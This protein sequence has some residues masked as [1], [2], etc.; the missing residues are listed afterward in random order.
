MCEGAVRVDAAL[1][2]QLQQAAG[3]LLGVRDVTELG[4]DGRQS[5]A[6]VLPELL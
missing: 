4:D 1:G 5:L 6:P 2:L 3:Q